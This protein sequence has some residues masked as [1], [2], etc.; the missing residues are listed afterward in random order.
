VCDLFGKICHSGG[1]YAGGAYRCNVK[2]TT[3]EECSNAMDGCRKCDPRTFTCALPATDKIACISEELALKAAIN[4][5]EISNV[6]LCSGSKFEISS[7][8]F[9]SRSGVVVDCI[10]EG[11]C[12][13]RQNGSGRF[14]TFNEGGGTVFGIRFESGFVSG[15]DGGALKMNGSNNKVVYCSF[16]NNAAKSGRGGAIYMSNGVLLYN[17]YGGNAAAQ[18]SDVYIGSTCSSK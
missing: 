4:N 1:G 14:F 18:C 12:T 3:S 17:S 13:M 8:M 11:T 9:V 2:C 5:P 16:V 15:Q 10:I 7:E 6:K